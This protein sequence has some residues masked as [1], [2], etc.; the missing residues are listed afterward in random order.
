[1]TPDGARTV[2]HPVRRSGRRPPAPLEALF[3]EHRYLSA[4]LGVIESRVRAPHR[5]KNGDF[6]LLRDVVAYLTD[7]PE[8]V[9][10]PTEDLIF[11]RV[12]RVDPAVAQSV[13]RLRA[14]H[15]AIARDAR[16]A[17]QRL[18][19][20]IERGGEKALERAL[21]ACAGLA[22]RYREHIRIENAEVFPAAMSSLSPEDWAEI[23]AG[24]RAAEDPLFGKKVGSE[25]RRLY[26]F[27]LDPAG[28]GA[29]TALDSTARVRERMLEGGEVLIEGF[30]AAADR[31]A[32]LAAE[33]SAHTRSAVSESLPPASLGSIVRLPGRYASGVGT[34][35]LGCS[36]DLL[37]IWARTARAVLNGAETERSDG[38]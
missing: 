11:E 18:D 35:L 33:I 15:A 10:H 37:R 36:T 22:K 28:P 19:A 38:R 26:E 23:G 5:L 25:H 13:A 17:A 8:H 9:H 31:C 6:Y 16:G 21:E 14:E 32:R 30:G 7:Y 27:L 12:L 24:Y 34:A 29:R 20:A 2:R 4:L 1:V 3:A